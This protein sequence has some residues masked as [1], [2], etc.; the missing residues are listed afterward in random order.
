MQGNNTVGITVVR[1]DLGYYIISLLL[2]LSKPRTME[3][4]RRV[5]HPVSLRRIDAEMKAAEQAFTCLLSAMVPSHVH[6]GRSSLLRPAGTC[7]FT[8]H[9]PERRDID[10]EPCAVE[11]PHRLAP[12]L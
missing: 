2:S 3:V 5:E 1:V 11:I 10:V 7:A 12:R 9:L 6:S 8:L 4:K